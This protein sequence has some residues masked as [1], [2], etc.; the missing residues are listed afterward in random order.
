VTVPAAAI[1]VAPGE[2]YRVRDLLTGAVYTWGEHNYVRLD[3]QI[4]P[5]HVLRV[6][7]RV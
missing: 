1:G 7:K 6:E 2:T 5:A 4:E 3:P